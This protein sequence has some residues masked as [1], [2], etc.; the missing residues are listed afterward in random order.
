MEPPGAGRPAHAAAAL[1]TPISQRAGQTLNDGTTRT[2]LTRG[3]RRRG[4]VPASPHWPCEPQDVAGLGPRRPRR[5]YE[6]AVG[7]VLEPATAGGDGGLGAVEAGH[8]AKQVL[9]VL[10]QLQLDGPGERRV[11]GQ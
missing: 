7:E 5:A 11:A 6:V 10:A 2:W 1:A 4:D 3:A 8:R 9:V